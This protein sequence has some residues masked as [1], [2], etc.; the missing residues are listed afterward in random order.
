MATAETGTTRVP[1]W[2]LW[3]GPL[4]LAAFLTV[5][6]LVTDPLSNIGDAPPVEEVAFER[7][8]FEPGVVTAQ[9]RNDGPDP[10][11]ISQV[12]VNDVYWPFEMESQELDRLESSTMRLNYPWEPGLPVILTV[13]S[14]TGATFEHEVPIATTTPDPASDDFFGLALVG[15]LIG[16]VPVAIGILWLPAVMRAGRAVLLFV[17]ALTVGL[18]LFLLVDTTLE[19]LELGLEAPASLDG[20]G[21]FWIAA[22]GAFAVLTIVGRLAETRAESSNIG[23]LALAYLVATGIGLHN[24]GEGLAVGAALASGATTLGASL[25]VGFALHNTTEGLAIVSPLGRGRTGP[26]IL[27]LVF[28]VLV[29]G[30][31]AILGAWLGAFTFSASWG[32]LAFGVAAGAIAQV[33]WQIAWGMRGDGGLARPVAL[34]GLFAGVA[35]M[36]VTGLFA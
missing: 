34:A 17:L 29:A 22:I 28:L 23:G 32:A 2:I 13:V 3:L 36:Y 16:V 12:L 1:S 27:H 21:L 6:L 11:R 7:V 15:L 30:A 14:S 5:G 18:L 20:V 35:L 10:V 19:G 9:V 4:G 24:L 31:P 25:V 33:V 26:R 8:E